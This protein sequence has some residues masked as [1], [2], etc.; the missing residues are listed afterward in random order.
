MYDDLLKWFYR[1]KPRR[2]DRPS[3]G[4]CFDHIAKLAGSRPVLPEID[5]LAWCEAKPAR[6]NAPSSAS[7]CGV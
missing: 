1:S 6:P 5:N 4:F 2:G 7:F 3:P